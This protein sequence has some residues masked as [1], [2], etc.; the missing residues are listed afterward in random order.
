MGNLKCLSLVALDLDG[1]AL[2]DTFS[3]I[4]YLL[5]KK[6]GIEYTS[7]VERNVFSQQRQ[8]AAAYLNDTFNLQMSNDELIR[9]YF[10]ERSAYL[11][12]FEHG[13]VPGLKEFLECVKTAGLKVVCYG[14][15][16]KGHFDK[17]MAEFTEY[18]DGEKYICTNDIRPGIRQ[19]V[20]DYYGL[21]YE[22]VLFIDDVSRVAEEAKSKNVPFIGVPS[23]FKHGFQRQD[24]LRV[25]VKHIVSSIREIDYRLLEQMDN[26]AVTGLLWKK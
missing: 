3:P 15:L 26:D 19:I 6:L 10:E 24:M 9:L 5:V 21:N 1:V 7:E 16:E 8:K 14:G 2:P 20:N 18:F 23:N 4:I 17:E 25:G 22:N 12:N 13:P 11:K